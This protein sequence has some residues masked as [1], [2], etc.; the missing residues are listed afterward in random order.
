[1]YATNSYCFPLT[2]QKQKDSLFHP[3]IRNKDGWF[4][5]IKS[6]TDVEE[7]VMTEYAMPI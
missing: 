4:I 1:M 5:A 7:N 2:W 6:S 3:S